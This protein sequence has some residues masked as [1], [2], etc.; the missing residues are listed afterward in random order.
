[1][2]Q[3]SL[4]KVLKYKKRV[5]SAIARVSNDIQSHNVVSHAAD[6]EPEREVDI[7]HLQND[8]KRLV[9]HLVWIKIL[10]MKANQPI[11]KDIF[12]LAEIK[13]TITF[14][15][16]IQTECGPILYGGDEFPRCQTSEI[17][18]AEVDEQIAKLEMEIDQIQDRLD[19][20]N[21]I[22]KIDIPN[23]GMV[24]E[25]RAGSSFS[26]KAQW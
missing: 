4:S 5:E 3:V 25:I 15:G 20:F 23:F 1:M 10:L 24:N 26:K 6:K 17:R 7:R 9:D 14:L 13:G 11:Y 18:K 8:R 12:Q 22:T 21:G 19:E 2:S 16:H